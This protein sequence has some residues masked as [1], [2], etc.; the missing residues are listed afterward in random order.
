MQ[1]DHNLF[2]TSYYAVFFILFSRL[3]TDVSVKLKVQKFSSIIQKL[4][5]ITIINQ[6][7]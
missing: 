3:L 4:K 5:S 2:R 1:L 6:L 7:L